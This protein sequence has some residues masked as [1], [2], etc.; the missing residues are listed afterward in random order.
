ML[1]NINIM[2]K[3]L[4]KVKPTTQEDRSKTEEDIL[5][6]LP[7]EKIMKIPDDEIILLPIS[8]AFKRNIDEI[9]HFI[10]NDMS[11]EEII[12]SF[13]I[14]RKNFEGIEP[15]Q[16]DMKT[17]CLY[18]LTS[19]TTELNYQAAEQGKWVETDKTIG[20]SFDSM[21]QKKSDEV[22][23][24]EYKQDRDVVKTVEKERIKNLDKKIKEAKVK[25]KK[26]NED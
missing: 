11:A 1:L 13:T 15:E 10:M 2:A 17:R 12:R 25:K 9:M 22:T 24:S 4:K 3:E 7:Q 16:I 6:K 20:D 5:K 21:I 23:L 14:I 19:I 26:S 8:G 18:T